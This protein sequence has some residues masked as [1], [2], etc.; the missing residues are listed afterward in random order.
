[1]QKLIDY[2][3]AQTNPFVNEIHF[4]QNNLKSE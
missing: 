4:L 3:L 2:A 1:M